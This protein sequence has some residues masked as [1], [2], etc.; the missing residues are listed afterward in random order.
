LGGA[1]W[2]LSP[3]DLVLWRLCGEVVTDA[4]MAG[5]SGLYDLDGRPVDALVGPAGPLLPAVVAP[6]SVVGH[7]QPG[8]AAQ[9]GVRPGVAVV[10][11]AGDRACEALGAGA[12]ASRPLVSWG[13]TANTSGVV[14]TRPH[15]VPPGLVLTPGA[16]GDWLLEGGLSAAGSLVTWLG[17]LT[18]R[19]PEDLAALA[20]GRPAGAR[21]VL[22][23]PWLDGARAPWWHDGARAA[24]LGL[25]AAHDAADLARAVYEAVAFDVVRCLRAMAPATGPASALA[26]GGAGAAAVVWTAVLTSVAGLAAQARRSAEAASAGAALLAWRALGDDRTIDDLDPV[27]HRVAPDQAEVA[28]YAALWA[29]AERAA[30]A[31]ID[32]DLGLTGGPDSTADPG[33]LPEGAAGAGPG[34]GNG[35][36]QAA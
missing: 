15:T 32:L 6:G 24:V 29:R 36:G 30:G 11:A 4:T 20:A 19:R 33:P 7:L 5:R 13:T 2:L 23:L 21:G 9:L 10:A 26:L 18:G 8:P 25:S 17:Q 12:S 22:V 35:S 27:G 31:V 3:R 14:V 28:R 34:P 16:S 1:A